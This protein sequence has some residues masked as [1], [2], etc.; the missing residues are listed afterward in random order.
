VSDLITWE[1]GETLVC[2][3]C[4]RERGGAD[5]PGSWFRHRPSRRRRI[6]IFGP[7]LEV[8]GHLEYVYL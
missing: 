1:P 6:P 3:L 5:P 2:V 4:E 7:E 8:L